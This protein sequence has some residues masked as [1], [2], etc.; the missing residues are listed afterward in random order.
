VKEGGTLAQA[1]GKF[2]VTKGGNCLE[3]WSYGRL[4]NFEGPAGAA[5]VP[6]PIRFSL[7]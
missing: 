6:T 5:S 3:F 2:Y 7:R 1:G 4:S